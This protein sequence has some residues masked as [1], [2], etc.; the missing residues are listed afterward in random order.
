MRIVYAMIMNRTCGPAHLIAMRVCKNCGQPKLKAKCA[1][2]SAKRIARYREANKARVQA[3]SRMYY[4]AMDQGAFEFMLTQQGNACAICRVLF[5]QTIK[6]YVDHDHSCC[7]DQRTCGKCTRGLLC[8]ECNKL[9]GRIEANSVF[10]THYQGY[11]DDYRLRK[12]RFAQ[13]I[14]PT[15]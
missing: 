10:S 6:P 15:V 13:T 5:T 14:P 12:F 7:K 1:P 8:N 4:Y 9:L 11:L 3:A 2:C